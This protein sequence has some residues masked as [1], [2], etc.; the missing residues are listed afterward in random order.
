M[1]NEAYVP[2]PQE[3]HRT[4]Y[5]FGQDNAPAQIQPRPWYFHGMIGFWVALIT[6]V[7]W[8]PK[9][10]VIIVMVVGMIGMWATI[11]GYAMAK[12]GQP[13][14]PENFNLTKITRL[15][16]G[17]VLVGGVTDLWLHIA[18]LPLAL[19]AVPTAIMFGVGAFVSWKTFNR[20]GLDRY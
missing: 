6:G 8:T 5:S 4:S 16:I 15:S 9:P 13:R 17:A 18:E 2:A 1:E 14:L 7:L 3:S 20:L 12:G 10:T 11:A 19:M